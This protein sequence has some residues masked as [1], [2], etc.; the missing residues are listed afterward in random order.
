MTLGAVSFSDPIMLAGLLAAGIP[1]ALHLLNRIRSPII[2]FPTLRFLKI[3]AQKTSRRR[4]VQHYLLLLLRMAVF[5]MIAMA[6]AHPLIRGGSST[7][8]YSFIAMFLGGLG[9]L[10]LA[11]GWGAAAIDKRKSTAPTPARTSADEKS[12]TPTGAKTY[13]TLSTA[14]FLIALL[15]TGYAVFGLTSASYFSGDKG[16]FSG[17]STAAVLLLDNSHSMLAKE[18]GQSRLDSAKKQIR[19]LLVETLH[20]AQAAILATNPGLSPTTESLTTDMTNLVGSLDSLQPTGRAR[21]MKERIHTAVDTLLQSSSPSKMLIILS[22]FAKPAF[23]DAEV[24]SALKQAEGAAAKD[25]QIMLMPMGHATPP[26][27]I[28]ISSFA[29]AEGSSAPV[30]GG[31]VTLEAQVINNSDAAQVKDLDLLVDGQ[32]TTPADSTAL[33]VQLGPA[34]T[35]NARSTLKLP[36]RLTDA[37]PHLFTLKLKDADDAMPWDDQRSLV[38]NV[39]DAVKVLVLGPDPSARGPRPRSAAFFFQAALAPFAGSDIKDAAGKPMPWPI[40]PTYRGINE[41]QN[42][43]ALA[44]YTAIFLCD[45]PTIPPKFADLLTR[46]VQAGDGTGRLIW[47]LGPSVNGPNYNQTLLPR[48]LLPASLGDPLV[49]PAGSPIDWV[50]LQS[51][52]FANLFDN[53]EPFRTAIVTGRWSIPASTTARPLIKLTDNS[54]LLTQ[55]HGPGGAGDIYTLLTSPSAAWSNLG[56]TVLLVPMASRM[57]LGDSGHSKTATSYET[58]DNL[59]IPV[60][61]AIARMSKIT[62]D[63][64][65]PTNEILNTRAVLTTP[66]TPQWYFDRT[67]TEGAYRWRSSDGKLAGLFAVNPPADE[68]DLAAADPTELATEATTAADAPAGHAALVAHSAEELLAQLQKRSEGT[69]LAP[70]IIGM[71]LILAVLEALLANRYRPAPRNLM[72]SRPTA[73][74]APQTTLAA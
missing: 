48:N 6:V 28:G 31:E 5:A 65:L 70:G 35:G 9:L 25:I 74:P 63:V 50:D 55:H 66:T 57:A 73:S 43:A 4:H 2:P 52:I 1:V 24:F 19:N 27:D 69:T 34:G 32:S 36:Y 17:R 72:E 60:R 56:S 14:A 12:P 71:V 47:I 45:L 51:D 40:A 61:N 16:E 46:Y 58:G 29:L 54:V 23:A 49:A 42:D 39:A 13:W 8:A 26:A 67:L 15:L 68:V 22:D 33:R 37:G 53:Q 44:G 11:A 41:I 62:L 30:V 21:P 7:L 18:D 59:F 10:V 38:L 64:T 3:T 20:P